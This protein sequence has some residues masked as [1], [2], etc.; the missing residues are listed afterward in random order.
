M[1]LGTDE[2]TAINQLITDAIATSQISDREASGKRLEARLAK[3]TEDITG[4]VTT[5]I[6]GLKQ[7]ESEVDKKKGK[8]D[9][10]ANS[11]VTAKLA[12]MQAKIDAAE[13]A[14][15][16]AES[17][18]KEQAMLNAF[19][20]AAGNAGVTRDRV[21]HLRAVVHSADGRLQYRDDGT[22]GMQ[23]KRDGYDEIVDF[24]DA[25]PQFLK[26]DG[27]KHFLPASNVT[28]TGAGEKGSHRR[29]LNSGGKF[30]AENASHAL[31]GSIRLV[32][33]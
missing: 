5:A 17:T 33:G 13:E 6:A 31:A 9:N 11:E 2:I 16:T 4:T 8:E 18:S 7:P 26:T 12:A 24:E 3:L 23:F 32:T 28:G 25:L 20:E 14:R 15:N 22:F 10:S 19:N 1:P 27:G 30:D 29:T 21:A